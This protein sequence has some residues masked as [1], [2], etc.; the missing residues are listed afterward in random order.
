MH[1]PFGGWAEARREPRPERARGCSSKQPNTR[2]TPRCLF[3]ILKAVEHGAAIT[4][5]FPKE[6]Q[7]SFFRALT[8]DFGKVQAIFEAFSVANAAASV[9]ED[10]WMIWRLIQSDCGSRQAVESI[11]ETLGLDISDEVRGLGGKRFY[12][13]I[14][15]VL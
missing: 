6:Q 12:K 10:K 11:C 15:L 1:F 8:T 2:V 3:E 5:A 7:A 9:E 4:M 13:N 14:Q